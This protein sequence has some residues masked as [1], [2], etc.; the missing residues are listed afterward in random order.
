MGKIGFSDGNKFPTES[1]HLILDSGV[2]YSL[3]P[4]DDFTKLTQMLDTK[5]GVKCG[6][7][8]NKEKKKDNFSA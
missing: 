2:S 6:Q 4:S 8:E 3:I 1:N 5:Y 7:K